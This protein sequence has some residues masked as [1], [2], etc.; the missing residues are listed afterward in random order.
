MHD[1]GGELS[2]RNCPEGGAAFRVT[3]AVVAAVGDPPRE[4]RGPRAGAGL[5]PA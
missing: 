2:A 4:E 5:T 1:C 3:L